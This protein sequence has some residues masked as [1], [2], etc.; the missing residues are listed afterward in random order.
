MVPLVLIKRNRI[1]AK[2]KKAGSVS[3]QAA[4]TLE[5]ADV[6]KSDRNYPGLVAMMLREGV[7]VAGE[8]AGNRFFLG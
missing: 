4:V 1:L 2:L 3:P 8:E 6:A 7:I 5:Q